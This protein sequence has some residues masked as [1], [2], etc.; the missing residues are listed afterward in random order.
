MSEVCTNEHYGLTGTPS[1]KELCNPNFEILKESFYKSPIPDWTALWAAHHMGS[2]NEANSG[3]MSGVW[4]PGSTIGT[5]F[6]HRMMK[7][8]YHW[9][10]FWHFN[11]NENAMVPMFNIDS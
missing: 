5:L 2:I 7:H 4:V 11:H 3:F 8:S 6:H 9:K 1:G 10:Q